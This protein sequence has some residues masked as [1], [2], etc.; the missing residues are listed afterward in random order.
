MALLGKLFGSDQAIEKVA[1]GIG[2]MVFTK[3]EQSEQFIQTLKAYEPFKLAQRLV[4]MAVTSVYLFVWLISAVL[5]I[6][7]F[8]WADFLNLA[9]MLAEMNNDVLGLPFTLIVGFYFAG[10]AA[11]GIV[12]KVRNK[13]K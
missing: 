7:S 3:E 8:W 2:K 1:G 4:A 13:K 5:M 12:E 6:L 9:R 10:G 11:E